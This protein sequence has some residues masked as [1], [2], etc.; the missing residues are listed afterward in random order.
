MHIDSDS[1]YLD[2]EQATEHFGQHLA[3]SI[4][5]TFQPNDQWLLT[6]HGGIGMGKTAL[7]RACLQ[8]LGVTGRIKSPTYA[9]VESYTLPQLTIHHYDFY[10][11][12]TGQEMIDAGLSEQLNEAGLHC[13]EWPEKVMQHLPP[14]L[15]QLHYRLSNADDPS[16]GRIITLSST[17]PAGQAMIDHLMRDWQAITAPANAQVAE[18]LIV[19]TQIIA[20]AD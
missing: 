15:L 14:A 13:I 4:Q 20:Q 16:A 3:Q 18:S 10:R 7:I 2:S 6:F 5:T 17:H 9:L 11:L 12:Q 19:T 1:I 8:A